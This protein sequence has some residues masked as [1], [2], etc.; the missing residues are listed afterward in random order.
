MQVSEA[1]GRCKATITVPVAWTL[2]ETPPSAAAAA[3][4]AA[5][6]TAVVAS[7][8]SGGAAATD[9]QM[10]L[11]IGLIPC[12][13][14]MDKKLTKSSLRAM[15]PIPIGEG[16]TGLLAGA[17]IGLAAVF[18]L[19]TAATG[20]VCLV[21]EYQLVKKKKSE[22]SSWGLY[23]KKDVRGISLQFSK[24]MKENKWKEASRLCR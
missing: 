5:V 2:P 9:A 7:A 18:V 21:L 3:V 1:I 14:P 13:N 22:D 19:H 4:S 8:I 23:S 20:I 11:V 10:L 17:T 16:H 24:K 6:T 12:R 15:S